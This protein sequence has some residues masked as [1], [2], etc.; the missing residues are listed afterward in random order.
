V[1]VVAN[2]LQRE[3]LLVSALSGVV[4]GSGTWFVDS[5]ATCHMT[6]AR[7]LFKSFTESDSDLYVELGMGTKHAVQ[8]SRTMSL[9][10]ESRDV[11]R[12]TNVLWV[13]K[14]KK[15]VLLVSAIEEKGYDVL[16]QDEQVLFMPR[17]YSSHTAVVLGVRESNL[18]RIKGQP[19]RAMASSRVTEDKEQV[20]SKVV[21]TRRESDFRGIQPS[22]SGG[23]EQPSKSIKRKLDFKGS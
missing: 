17:G 7:E 23:K 1:D 6:G 10:M 12:L 8:G 18:Y 5:G 14:L 9:R 20:A 4:F 22:R 19:M 11:L 13:P 2:K 16:F 21:Q 3:I 15:S